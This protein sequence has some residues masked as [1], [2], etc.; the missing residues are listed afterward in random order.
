MR[1]SQQD[2]SLHDQPQLKCKIKTVLHQ[3]RVSC[4]R[5]TVLQAG[6]CSGNISAIKS[7]KISIS[8]ERFVISL[9]VTKKLSQTIDNDDC[10]DG[11]SDFN[12]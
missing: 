8:K 6:T 7:T 11:D 2:G 4:G 12:D 3:S 9:M 10:D 1:N 5:E